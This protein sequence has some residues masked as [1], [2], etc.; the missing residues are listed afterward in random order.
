MGSGGAT[1]ARSAFTGFLIC[2]LPSSFMARFISGTDL[3]SLASPLGL[4]LGHR[5]VPTPPST[6]MPCRCSSGDGTLQ[7]NTKDFSSDRRAGRPQRWPLSTPVCT[8]EEEGLDL[9]HRAGRAG[10][11]RPGLQTPG[12]LAPLCLPPHPG[13]TCHSSSSSL[14]F[15][16][17]LIFIFYRYIL[18]YAADKSFLNVVCEEG[19][20]HQIILE[21]ASSLPRGLCSLGP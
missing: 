18:L 7:S 4:L 14:L 5:F 12:L 15:L 2:S 21:S 10:Q 20:P 17:D 1:P 16:P 3:A 8:E 6:R 19:F 11:G 9:G 13:G